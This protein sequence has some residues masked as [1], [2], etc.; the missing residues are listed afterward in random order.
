MAEK[1]TGNSPIIRRRIELLFKFK[2]EK[3]LELEKDKKRL[4]YFA[5][6]LNSRDY[7]SLTSIEISRLINDSV[8]LALEVSLDEIEDDIALFRSKKFS[9]NGDLSRPSPLNLV[10]SYRGFDFSD[11]E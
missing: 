7:T 6:M 10:N 2:P 3:F 4:R 5:E 11:I 8:D 9:S 1:I